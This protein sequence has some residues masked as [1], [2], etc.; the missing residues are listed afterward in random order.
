MVAA[1]LT[2]SQTQQ[3]QTLALN[4]SSLAFTSTKSKHGAVVTSLRSPLFVRFRVGF[5]DFPCSLLTVRAFDRVVPSGSSLA[6]TSRCFT[7][8]S[9]DFL[10]KFCVLHRSPLVQPL[11]SRLFRVCPRFIFCTY[12]IP[13]S[14]LAN[15]EIHAGFHR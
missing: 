15:H 6:S 4:L 5:G 8:F 12:F 10:H 7:R 2:R 9:P 13:C 11:C 14:R 1:Q 3:I